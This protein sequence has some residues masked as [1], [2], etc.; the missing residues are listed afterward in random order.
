MSASTRRL[1]EA[2]RCEDRFSRHYEHRHEADELIAEP[3]EAALV[4]RGVDRSLVMAC[5][6]V[7]GEMLTI[8]LDR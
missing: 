5:P 4:H 3:G 2:P 1:H 6:N 7:C 8:N